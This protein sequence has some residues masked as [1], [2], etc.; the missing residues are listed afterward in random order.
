MRRGAIGRGMAPFDRGFAGGKRTVLAGNADSCR[1]SV[2][3]LWRLQTYGGPVVDASMFAT[4]GFVRDNLEE[5]SA[6]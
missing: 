1:R 6:G 3:R 4:A 2:A 5:Q